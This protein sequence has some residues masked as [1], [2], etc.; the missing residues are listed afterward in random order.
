M[1]TTVQETVLWVLVKLVILSMCP[2][3][4]MMGETRGIAYY[5]VY[6]FSELLE[7]FVIN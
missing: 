4:D 1:I 3:C 7:L 5:E 2:Y 6:R